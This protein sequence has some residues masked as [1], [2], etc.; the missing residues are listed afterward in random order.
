[1]Y[2]DSRIRSLCL[3]EQEVSIC[4]LEKPTLWAGLDRRWLQTS[5][6]KDIGLF[7]FF[8]SVIAKTQFA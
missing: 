8:I 3:S 2:S 7:L 6:L 5:N 1:M 4:G